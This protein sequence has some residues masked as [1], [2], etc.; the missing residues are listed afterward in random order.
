AGVTYGQLGAYLDNEG[1]ALHNLASLPHI[2]VVGACATATHGSGERNGNLATAVRAL[3]IVTADGKLIELRR[4]RD[5]ERFRG[6]VVNLGGLGLVARVT[7]AIE[8]TY[9]MRQ[10]VYVNL[11]FARLEEHF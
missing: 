10:D 3:T 2:S 7:L 11:P 9:T 1:F 4:D 8:P 6:A 5:G